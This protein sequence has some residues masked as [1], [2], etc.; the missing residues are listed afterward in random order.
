MADRSDESVERISALVD[1][2]LRADELVLAL[3]ELQSSADARA[4]WDTFHVLGDIMRTGDARQR[5]HDAQFVARLRQRMADSA[6]EMV[7]VP[8]LSISKTSESG[9]QPRSANDGSWRRVVGLF[10]VLVAAVLVWQEL[11]PVNPAVTS[12]MAQQAVPVVPV[13]QEVVPVAETTRQTVTALVDG[14]ESPG[15][16]IR[17]ARL[18]AILLAH[19]QFGGISALPMPA[20]FVRSAVLEESVR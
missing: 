15:V 1:G 13:K 11:S 7:A 17:D 4:D 9:S 3:A 6:V 20:G 2:Q 14:S 16:M 5:A 10:S 18:D 19:R 8:A 12:H